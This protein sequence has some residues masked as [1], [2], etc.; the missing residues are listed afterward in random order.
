M[1][2]YG[3]DV[4]TRGQSEGF[5]PWEKR[6]VDLHSVRGRAGVRPSPRLAEVSLRFGLPDCGTTTTL[7]E[8]ARVTLGPGRVVLL[9]GPSGSGKSAALSA[10]ESQFA[11]ACTVQRVAF[12]AEQAVI[13][14]I[15]PEGSLSDAI[16]LLTACGLGEAGLW[17]RP[18]EALSDGEQFRARLACAIAWHSRSSGAA[19]LLCDEFCTG[20]HRR[21][22]KAIAYNLHRLAVRKNL[23]VVVASSNDDIVADL[24]PHAVV[25]LAGRGACRVEERRVLS[26]R[27]VSFFRQLRIEPGCKRDYEAFAAMHYR[28]A[29]EL[30][31][32]DKVFVLRDGPGGDA[33]GIV[34]Y[35]H[36]PLELAMR[37]AAT[38]GWFSR[39][40]ARV[41]R[42]LRILRRLVMHPDVRGCG[43]GHHLV[44]NTLRLPGTRYVECLAAMGEFNPVFEKAGMKRIGQYGA[45]RR[46]L[47]GLEA[48]RAMGVDH[49]APEFAVHVARRRGVRAIVMRVVHDWYAGTTGGGERRIAR[50][51]SEFIAQTFRGLIGIRPVYYLW[52]RDVPDRD[53]WNPVGGIVDC[54]ENRSRKTEARALKSNPFERPGVEQSEKT[55]NLPSSLLHNP[56]GARRAARPRRGHAAGPKGRRKDEDRSSKIENGAESPGAPGQA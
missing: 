37:N 18:F 4:A 11:T 22:A 28:G 17:L 52:R 23:C 43:L 31:F 35:A 39:N 34:V 53:T 9:S 30:G 13:D 50:Q 3:G 54:D 21:L 19:P 48:L 51:S 6:T 5:L 27:A 12:L 40:P 32:V 45:D 2:K 26:K 36:A 1:G 29:D 55:T 49:R 14:R 38:N 16:A 7:V 8:S 56:P 47:A 24:N 44:R 15:A 33:L 25:H 42:H 46:R 10:I 41:N 20:L